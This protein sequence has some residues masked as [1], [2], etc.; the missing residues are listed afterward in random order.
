L[1]VDDDPFNRRMLVRAL[2]HEGHETFEAGD[3]LEGLKMLQEL[4]PDVML[5]DVV[6]PELDGSVYSPR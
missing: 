6:R 2:Q 4:E 1:V 5:L 3:G